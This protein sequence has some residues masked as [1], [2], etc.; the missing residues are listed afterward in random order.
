MNKQRKIIWNCLILA[1][2]LGFT[3]PVKVSAVEN[4]QPRVMVTDYELEG[5][6]IIPG[7]SSQLILTLKNMNYEYSVYSVLITCQSS[8]TDGT[9]NV[10]AEYGTSN[11]AYIDTMG[12]G[13]QKQTVISLQAA[14]TLA[15][16]RIDCTLNIS[17]KDNVNGMS[18]T[19]TVIQLPIKQDNLKIKRAYVPKTAVLGAKNRISA[20]YENIQNEEIYNAVMTV[21]GSGMESRSI[22]LG[23]VSS[24]SRKSQEVYIVFDSLGEQSI[25]VEL[26]YEDA[27]GNTYITKTKSYQVEVLSNAEDNIHGGD[28]QTITTSQNIVIL[29][30]AGCVAAI[31][32][33][34][35]G[36]VFITR[37][38]KKH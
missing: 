37:R 10:S 9:P 8:A 5:G 14:D 21:R 7:E 11:Q 6:G 32:L 1:V 28:N 27:K 2:I 20:T 36:F 33:C 23:T 17:F 29:K 31:I 22:E 35:A 19:D 15:S 12:P 34:I 18:S 26:S 38:E 13:E 25:S 30:Q 24:G 3:I 4:D 16:E